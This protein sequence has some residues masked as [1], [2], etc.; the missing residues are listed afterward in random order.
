MGENKMSERHA[1]SPKNAAAWLVAAATTG[2]LVATWVF[3]GVSLGQRTTDTKTTV[4]N[5]TDVVAIERSVL[6]N[7]RAHSGTLSSSKTTFPGITGTITAHPAKTNAPLNDG[8]AVLEVNG[9]PIYAANIPFTLWRDITPGTTGRDILAI[10]TWLHTLKHIPTNSNNPTYDDEL[11]AGINQLTKEAPS[12]PQGTLAANQLANINSKQTRLDLKN[13]TIGAILNETN[14]FTLTSAYQVITFQDEGELA[15]SGTDYSHAKITIGSP[16]AGDATTLKIATVTHDDQRSIMT[17]AEPIQREPGPTTIFIETGRTT[18]EVLSVSKR[19]IRTVD[20]KNI[21][22]LIR[23][24][25]PQDIPVDLGFDAGTR[26][27]IQSD[28]VKAGDH[29]ALP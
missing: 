26:I 27:E 25:Q 6:A 20:G 12:G 24:D 11:A 10:R 9:Q 15:Q 28:N 17:L 1:G 14:P 16:A 22:R 23:D 5:A 8:Q 21:V 29:I 19:A 3:L 7:S 13:D 18:S 4:D 2:A